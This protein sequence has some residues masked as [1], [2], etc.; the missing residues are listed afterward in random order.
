M[1]SFADFQWNPKKSH[2]EPF[3]R[4]LSNNLSKEPLVFLNNLKGPVPGDRWLQNPFIL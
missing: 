4:I 1:T 3:P 2:V